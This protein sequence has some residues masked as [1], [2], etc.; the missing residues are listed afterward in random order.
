MKNMGFGRANDKI[1]L[2]VVFPATFDSTIRHT[3]SFPNEQMKE[4]FHDLVL[5]AAVLELHP[6]SEA[7][8]PV[9][10][11]QRKWAAQRS[12][13]RFA[14]QMRPIPHD[15]VPQLVTTMH[16]IMR[17]LVEQPELTDRIRPM[18]GFVI[19][20]EIQDIKLST[21][22]Q[23][24][25]AA[26]ADHDSSYIQS[27]RAAI[28][29]AFSETNMRSLVAE[30]TYVDLAVEMSAP[31]QSLYFRE[32]GHALIL[33]YILGYS[34]GAAARSVS[35]TSQGA[36]YQKDCMVG[37]GDVAGFHFNLKGEACP[38]GYLYAQAYHTEK[39]I[40]Y[41]ASSKNKIV[42]LDA[43]EMLRPQSEERQRFREW[44]LSAMSALVKQQENG[45]RNRARLEIT[46]DL[47]R[48]EQ[49]NINFSGALIRNCIVGLEPETI[50]WVF[51][52][53][54]NGS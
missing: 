22:F 43:I 25:L 26:P 11:Q 53:F 28:N 23:P 9:S 41:Q 50:P 1:R 44:I 12:N 39:E 32:D 19:A 45:V 7:H 14:Y 40:G 8:W 34:E 29:I 35:S 36:R 46:T 24:D 52:V 5:R 10:Y 6:N 48:L 33:Q 54:G 38:N 3:V 15:H 13:G 49:A 18:V 31:N 17:S 2:R 47:S 16:R 30:N 21:A 4:D 37:L 42:P 27:L 20:W 51:N